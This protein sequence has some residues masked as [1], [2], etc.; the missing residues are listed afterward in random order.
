MN[1]CFSFLVL[2]FSILYSNCYSQKLDIYEISRYGTVN[3][4]KALIS[5][6][7]SLLNKP[8]ES[9]YTPLILASYRGNLDVVK[10]LVSEGAEIDYKCEGGTALAGASYRG[11]LEIVKILLNNKAN[12]NIQDQSGKTPLHYAV[13]A[14]NI[15]V[16]KILLKYNADKTLSDKE[17]KTAFEY[18]IESKNQELICS[19]KS[20]I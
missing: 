2:F 7:K 15:E 20:D 1:K 16:I 18:A 8:N 10:Y 3:E 19:L 14:Q 11:N 5:Y 6:N 17:Q 9:G 12:P 13:I 4:A